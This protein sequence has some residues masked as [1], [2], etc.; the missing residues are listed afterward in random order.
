V[1]I[2]ANLEA[3]R[4]RIETSCRSVGRDPEEVTLIAVSKNQSVHAIQEAY[5]LGCRNFGESR[6]QE[7]VPK[8]AA[9]PNDVIWHFIGVLQTNKAKRIASLFPFVHTFCKESQLSEA[10]KAENPIEGFIE[11][12]IADEEQK[13]GVHPRMLDG[14]HA[15]LIQSRHVHFRGLM[16]IG[17]ADVGPD[18]I[19]SYFKE[20]KALADK[21][22]SSSISMGMSNDFDV[23]IQEGASH[24]RIGTAIFGS[25]Q[26]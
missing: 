14:Y 10:D 18:V 17:P 9:L 5:E 21:L 11:V 4:S 13:S 24:I 1:S 3:V 2:R 7:A 15:K 25:R 6:L 19:R 12:N 22:E 23:A 26:Y 16:S 20:L 8:I